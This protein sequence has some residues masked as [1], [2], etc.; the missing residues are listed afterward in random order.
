LEIPISQR[1]ALYFDSRA[2][3]AIGSG[4]SDIGQG[5]GGTWGTIGTAGMIG[6]MFGG[7]FS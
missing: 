6:G 2:Q 7:P 5:L 3:E 4:L 1:M